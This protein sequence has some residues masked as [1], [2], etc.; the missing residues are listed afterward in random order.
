M[1][2]IDAPRNFRAA[3]P[4]VA[5]PATLNCFSVD[6]EE[7]FHA[8]VFAPHVPRSQWAVLPRRAAPFVERLAD[9]LEFNHSR[10]TFFILGDTLPQLAGL[11]RNLARAGHE[12]ACHGQGHV[13]IARLA[14]DALREDL[15]RARGALGDLLG[16]AP[17][18]YRAPTFSV[19]PR[20]AWA[21]DVIAEAGFE[22]DASVFPVRHDRYGVP[23]APR[24]PFWA[25]TPGGRRVLEFPPL[26]TALGPWRLPVG[27]GGYL[28]LLPGAVLRHCLNAA[29]R[30]GDASMLYVH[31]WEL[32]EQQPELACSR[33]GRWRHRVN[34][35]TTGDKLA[36][37]MATFSFDTAAA[38]LARVQALKTL[39]EYR[40]DGAAQA[41]NQA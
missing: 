40:I 5:V 30:A 26:T 22:Y 25:R 14:S 19:T 4:P 23:K 3:A 8:E 29:Q 32:D 21:L 31:P 16:T 37:L 20:T 34:L 27:G 38:V 9:L 10:G 12:I 18:G 15:R 1:T 11:I 36:R 24:V 7:Y 13:H 6:V 33:V 28:R 2:A 41:A 17:R 39:P 35:H